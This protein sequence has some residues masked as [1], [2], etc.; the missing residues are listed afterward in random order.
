MRSELVCQP[1]EKPPRLQQAELRR[2]DWKG[3][4]FSVPAQEDLLED[5]ACCIVC[6]GLFAN[7]QC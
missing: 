4:I 5:L 3:R 7:C 1:P 6:E 2:P